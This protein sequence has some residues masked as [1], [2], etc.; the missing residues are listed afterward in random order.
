MAMLETISLHDLKKN[1]RRIIA[2]VKRGETL[3]I[4]ERGQ[5]VAR[6]EPAHPQ[7]A[8]SWEDIMAPVYKAAREKGATHPNPVLGERARR[9][10]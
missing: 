10:R 8:P 7:Q 6:L 2:R 9:R 5:P 3:T 1:Q 4:T